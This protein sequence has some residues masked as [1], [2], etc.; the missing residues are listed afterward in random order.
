MMFFLILNVFNNCRYLAFCIRKS[1]ITFLPGK[2]MWTYTLLINPLTAFSFYI[3]YQC[4]YG[5]MRPHAYENMDM[6][7]HAVYLQHFM[8]VFLE[9]AGNISVKTFFPFI[10]DQCISAF[11][12]E[13]ELNVNLCIGVRHNACNLTKKCQSFH[14]RGVPMEHKNIISFYPRNVPMGHKNRCSIG[15]PRG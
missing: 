3:L 8:V 10:A 2:I 1:A 6:V 15:T 5:L 9:N 14:P 11:N 13:Y 4:R 12:G 7:G